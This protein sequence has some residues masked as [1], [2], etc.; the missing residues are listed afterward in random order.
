MGQGF[1]QI[2]LTLCIVIAITPLL[3][4]YI[5]RVFWEENTLLDPLMNPIETSIYVLAGVR[6]KDEMRG[7]QYIRSVL[8]SNLLMGILVYL[9]IYFQRVLPWNPNGFGIPSW[10]TMMHTVVS[11]LTNTD[12]QHYA[13]ETTFSYFT[14]VAA[15]GFL[16]FT[17]VELD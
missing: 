6:R 3:G 12:Q 2:G 1:L 8:I 5:A 16:M 15:L 17:S 11:F 14:Q 10:D 7:G 9:L 4:K 13:P